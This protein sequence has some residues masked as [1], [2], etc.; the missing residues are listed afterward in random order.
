M[1]VGSGWALAILS[2]PIRLHPQNAKPDVTW[3]SQHTCQQS[4]ASTCPCHLL[5]GSTIAKLPL[6]RSPRA[7]A[8]GWAASAVLDWGLEP[9]WHLLSH[10][11]QA[12]SDPVF[13]FTGSLT[14]VCPASSP[15]R[16]LSTSLG[17]PGSGELPCLAWQWKG[18]TL[19]PA[20]TPLQS[21][22]LPVQPEATGLVWL[23]GAGPGLLPPTCEGS[24][25]L[26]CVCLTR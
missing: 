15:C 1:L 25:H 5:P 10:H 19:T 3:Y 9:E 6:Q 24:F 14:N 26:G 20:V 11:F 13:K 23:V 22:S 2:C 12:R 18:A 17:F 21:A 8:W 7:A 16:T 4:L